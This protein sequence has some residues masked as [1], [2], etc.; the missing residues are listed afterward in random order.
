MILSMTAFA[1]AKHAIPPVSV[2]CEIRGCNSKSLDISLRL[3]SGYIALEEKIKSLISEKIS[4]G[5]LDIQLQIS[6]TADVPTAFELD[7]PRA[8]AYYQILSHINEQFSLNAPISLDVMVAAGIIKPAEPEK[9]ITSVWAVVEPCLSDAICRLIDMRK[10]EGAFLS[11]DIR[12]RLALIETHLTHIQSDSE[13]LLE[14]YRD[15]L[16]HRIQKLTQGLVDID[17]GRIAQEAA[18]LADRSDIS[19]EIVRAD[20]HIHQFRTIMDAPEPAGRKLNFLLQEMNREFNTMGS[21]T[22]SASVSYRVVEVKTELEKIRE[23][24]QNIE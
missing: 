10:Q 12:N 24:V 1:S 9:D 18:F 15:R 8:R 6:E 22:E 17:P 13:G 21:K 7:E 16:I 20:S 5:R 19:E 3:T 23:Q 4:R 11:E 14:Y 2:T